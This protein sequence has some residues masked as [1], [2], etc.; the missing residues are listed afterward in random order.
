MVVP[1]PSAIMQFQHTA[2]AWPRNVGMPAGI[3]STPDAVSAL[4]RGLWTLQ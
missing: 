4:E 1:N 3:S 2:R